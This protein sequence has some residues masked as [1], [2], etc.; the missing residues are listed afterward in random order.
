MKQYNFIKDSFAKVFENSNF[1]NAKSI[2]EVGCGSGANL[3]LFNKLGLEV[4]GIDYSKPLIDI[5]KKVLVS[6]DIICDE[7]INIPLPSSLNS[8]IYDFMLSNSVFSYFPNIEYANI[9]LEKMYDKCRYAIGLIDIH[10]IKK[11][12]DFI[13]YRIKTIKNYTEKYNGL[14]KL[15][16]S[17]D[18]FIEFAQKHNM[19]IH[20]SNSDIDGYWNN[21]FVFNCFMYKTREQNDKCNINGFRSGQKN[22][23]VNL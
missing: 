23:A 20:F 3:Y 2:Y 8:G 5:A 9:V 14:N 17:K 6:S 18:F 19:K 22:A 16:Y 10:D 7:A 13:E 12:K 21:E 15:F 1:S 11:E 4:G